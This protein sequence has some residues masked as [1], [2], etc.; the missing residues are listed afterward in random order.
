MELALLCD[1]KVF[2]CLFDHSNTKLIQ[3]NSHSFEE[4]LNLLK[5]VPRSQ[6]EILKNEDVSEAPNLSITQSL[7]M[8]T[9]NK[10]S[11]LF[12]ETRRRRKPLRQSQASDTR[13]WVPCKW[14]VRRN[15]LSKARNDKSSPNK[16]YNLKIMEA[17]WGMMELTILGIK[18][19][20]SV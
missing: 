9:I 10:R 6:T 20:W 2:L 17:L 18:V 19:M 16:I 5:V 14:V 15:P 7:E 1:V 3:Y 4:L 11:H 8:R 12:L 13:A